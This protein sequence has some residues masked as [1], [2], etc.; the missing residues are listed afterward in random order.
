GYLSHV[1][2][3]E[4]GLLLAEASHPEGALGTLDE[5]VSLRSEARLGDSV[6]EAQLLA[7]LYLRRP[8]RRFEER[9]R[10]CFTIAD[11]AVAPA[12]IRDRIAA[13]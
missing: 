12:L 7:R 2:T 5:Q 11:E 8:D 10:A 4:L 13:A 1:A 3:R 9:F 6:E